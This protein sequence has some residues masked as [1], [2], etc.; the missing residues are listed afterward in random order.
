MIRLVDARKS[1]G[2]QNLYDGIDASINAGER[3]GLPGKNGSGKTTLFRVLMGQ[4]TLDS[5]ELLRDRKCSIGY[6]P[7]EIHPLR[8][9][10]VFECMLEHLGPWTRADRQ[11]KDVMRGLE[12][13]DPRALERYDDAMEAFVSA[14]GYE[15][16]AR[17]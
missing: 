14:G 9:G 5:G 12:E 10:T 11:L 7:Q 16:E 3:I 17:A 2:R 6:L 13:G 1:Y 15:M 8:E 4:E